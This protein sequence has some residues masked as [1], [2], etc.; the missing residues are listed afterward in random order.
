MLIVFENLIKKRGGYMYNLDYKNARKVGGF[1]LPFLLA[2]LLVVAIAVGG[3]VSKIIKRSRMD[4]I[5]EAYDV[6]INSR[7]DSE[8]DVSYK[9]TYYYKVDGITYCYTTSFSTSV[10]VNKMNNSTIYYNKNNPHDAIS[11]Y[12]MEEKFTSII[13]FFIGAIFAGFGFHQIKISVRQIK[14]MKKLASDG[15]LIRNL[16]Y[17]MVPSNYSVNDRPVMAIAVDYEL[18]SGSVVT[19]VGEPRF[20]GKNM[21][22]D[23]YV[24]L[25]IDLDDPNNY[26]IDF[27]ISLK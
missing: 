12:E 18:P 22:E 15:M 11:E 16:E 25:L 8:G 4:G 6:E 13:I 1:G 20:D 7:V 14:K 26:Y 9:P 17:R 19:L 2:G 5:V 3:V 21:D 10:N 23:G 27:N 24:D